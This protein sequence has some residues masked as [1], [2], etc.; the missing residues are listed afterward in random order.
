VEPDTNGC[1][2]GQE[3]RVRLAVPGSANRGPAAHSCMQPWSSRVSGPLQT[4]PSDF[5]PPLPFRRGRSPLD[6]GRALLHQRDRLGRATYR[7]ERVQQL[8]GH[9]A[10]KQTKLGQGSRIASTSIVIRSSGHRHARQRRHACDSA[11]T[12]NQVFGL[13]TTVLP[14][15]TECRWGRIGFRDFRMA[16]QRLMYLTGPGKP[17]SWDHRLASAG[18]PPAVPGWQ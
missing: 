8:T 7:R 11:R 5:Q 13:E 4:A 18:D 12:C 2:E 15:A 14:T 6:S 10:R 16:A 17:V 1:T 3:Q 9:D